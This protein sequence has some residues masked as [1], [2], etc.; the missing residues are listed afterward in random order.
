MS[1]QKGPQITLEHKRVPFAGVGAP[2]E[3]ISQIKVVITRRRLIG[4]N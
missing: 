3:I 1:I 2:A 4:A